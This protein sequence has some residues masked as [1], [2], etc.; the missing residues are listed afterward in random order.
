MAKLGSMIGLGHFWTSFFEVAGA[1]GV[2]ACAFHDTQ[3]WL[4]GLGTGGGGVGNLLPLKFIT[5]KMKAWR[6]QTNRSGWPNEL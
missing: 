4:G 2:F 1:M 5:I 3:A 6:I